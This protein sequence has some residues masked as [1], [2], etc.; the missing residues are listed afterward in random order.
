MAGILV[1]H[2]S[3]TEAEQLGRMLSEQGPVVVTDQA[4][5]M[6]ECLLSREAA[7]FDLVLI[8]S[9]LPQADRL[10]EAAWSQRPRASVAV[11]DGLVAICGATERMNVAPASG[12]EGRD[13]WCTRCTA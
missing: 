3:R 2:R 12:P 11:V 10:I 6:L 5:V 9:S 7:S 1:A 13:E 8:D 4:V